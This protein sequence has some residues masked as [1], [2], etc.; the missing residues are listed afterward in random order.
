MP[1]CAL[2]APT[3]PSCKRNVVAKRLWR[4]PGG[5]CDRTPLPTTKQG[6]RPR[7]LDPVT[8]PR[9]PALQPQRS[10]STRAQLHAS[11]IATR[12]STG[13][14]FGVGHNFGF[15]QASGF[16]GDGGGEDGGLRTR[17]ANG[18]SRPSQGPLA[19]GAGVVG[20]AGRRGGSFGAPPWSAPRS[21]LRP[22]SSSSVSTAQPPMSPFGPASG[23]APFS[24]MSQGPLPAPHRHRPGTTDGVGPQDHVD[25]MYVSS[26]RIA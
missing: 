23:F 19:D 2:A 10:H 15:G 17:S 6:H 7:T 16:D 3:S 25:H 8:T 12:P 20:G 22:S 26:P 5:D 21:T 13:V 18:F 24:P 9:P 1:S 14:G 11:P 4:V